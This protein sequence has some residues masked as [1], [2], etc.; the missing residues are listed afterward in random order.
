M[1]IRALEHFANLL[2]GNCPLN[3]VGIYGL[4]NSLTRRF[5]IHHIVCWF[6]P[7]GHYKSLQMQL[8]ERGYA[9]LL[10][11]EEMAECRGNARPRQ[12]DYLPTDTH[13]H[14]CLPNHRLPEYM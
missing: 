13:K 3:V 9:T 12:A 2:S 1:F 7:L 10:S 6:L 11:M 14:Q 8:L 4:P 5:I